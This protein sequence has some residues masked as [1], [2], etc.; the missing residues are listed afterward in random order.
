MDRTA[1][2][3]ARYEAQQR[4]YMMS[5]S[6]LAEAIATAWAKVQDWTGYEEVAAERIRQYHILTDEREKR[7]MGMW[8]DQDDN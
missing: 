6:E 2:Q 5:N 1:E 3:Y 4:A 7:R 8:W